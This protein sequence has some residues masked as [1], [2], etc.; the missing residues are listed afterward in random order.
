[1]VNNRSSSTLAILKTTTTE[2]STS[3]QTTVEPPSPTTSAE[4]SNVLTATVT[5][6]RDECSLKGLKFEAD[7]EVEVQ[8]P[9][10]GLLE[11]LLADHLDFSADF[12]ISSP[13]RD[14]MICSPRRDFMLISSPKRDYMISSPRRDYMMSSPKREY[15]VLSP[16]RTTGLEAPPPSLIH[17]NYS[18]N[19]KSQSPLQKVS[20]CSIYAPPYSSPVTDFL[21]GESLAL[22]AV[23][24][25]LEDYGR[26]GYEMHSVKCGADQFSSEATPYSGAALPPTPAAAALPSLLDCFVMESRYGSQMMAAGIN[27]C[28]EEDAAY[29]HY[30]GGAAAAHA[31]YEESQQKAQMGHGF[32]N[33]VGSTS[34]VSSDTNTSAAVE[35]ALY[36]GIVGDTTSSIVSSEHEQ[37]RLLDYSFLLFY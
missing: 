12:M 2:G 7:N 15:M 6:E 17:Y 8:S 28:A 3:K 34:I 30:G 33:S 5:E 24:A 16:R 32:V 1:M 36:H 11:S 4:E 27:F 37:V 14:Y 18:N 26:E 13:R 9:D 21:H 19:S 31:Q 35:A 29:Q 23:D 10:R 20:N 22:P 25:Y